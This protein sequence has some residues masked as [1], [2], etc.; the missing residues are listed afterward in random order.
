MS[1]FLLIKLILRH[2]MFI[3]LPLFALSM[4][5]KQQQLSTT[6]KKRLSSQKLSKTANSLSSAM[7]SLTTSWEEP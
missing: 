5:P 3:L 2:H 6:A 7:A 4:S 1:L